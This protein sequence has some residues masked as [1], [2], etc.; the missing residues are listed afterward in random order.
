MGQNRLF[1][2]KYKDNCSLNRYPQDSCHLLKMVKKL[3]LNKGWFKKN[4]LMEFSFKLAGWGCCNNC[5][6]D[7]CPRRQLS[8]GLLSN[9]TVVQADYSP[10]F[11]CF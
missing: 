7:L 8:K 5:P 3:Y 9:D 10:E 2:S 6:R 4:E 1:V 11:V